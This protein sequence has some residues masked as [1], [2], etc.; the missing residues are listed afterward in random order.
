MHP[1]VKKQNGIGEREYV[2]LPC[3]G[4]GAEKDEH[5]AIAVLGHPPG[6]FADAR[7]IGWVTKNPS[8]PRVGEAVV[9]GQEKGGRCD[10]PRHAR[11]AAGVKVKRAEPL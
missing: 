7:S 4:L 9:L 6:P 5:Y 2:P 8:L 1:P 10:A 11:A 3:G